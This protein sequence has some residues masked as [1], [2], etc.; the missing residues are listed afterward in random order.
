MWSLL[1]CE[2]VYK[3]IDLL[4]ILLSVV[5]ISRDGKSCNAELQAELELWV[6]FP[7]H[8]IYIFFFKENTGKLME[9]DWDCWKMRGFWQK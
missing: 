3:N 8:E 4:C 1:M 5:E 7:L 9:I 6:Q 2:L